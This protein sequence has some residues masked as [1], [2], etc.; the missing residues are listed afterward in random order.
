MEIYTKPR[1]FAVVLF[2]PLHPLS[3]HL[4]KASCTSRHIIVCV[5]TYIW[6]TISVDI[7]SS[8][9]IFKLLMSSRIDS[10]LCS[11]AGRYNNPIPS[12][13]LARLDSL[14][15][16]A[17][18]K[19]WR[20]ESVERLQEPN[21]GQCGANILFLT[22]PVFVNL[23]RST[24]NRCLAWR[25]RFLGSLNVYKYGL[26]A[27]ESTYAGFTSFPAWGNLCKEISYSSPSAV[28]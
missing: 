1:D 26:C 15:I 14:K 17:L 27:Y 11:L 8:A 20:K 23:S 13:F 19:P 21:K 24:R 22:D 10:S 12:R 18:I 16:P 4:G 6:G 9:R 3:S 7:T 28:S 2:G 5:V 25:N